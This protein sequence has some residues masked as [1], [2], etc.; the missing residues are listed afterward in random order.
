[1]RDAALYVLSVPLGSSRAEVLLQQSFHKYSLDHRDRRLQTELVYG[2]IRNLISLDHSLSFYMKE[3][4][5]VQPELKNILRLAAYQLL[6]L[7]K[8]PA[9]A[10]VDEAVKQAKKS[11]GRGG[12]GAGGFVNAVLRNML[13]EPG[14]VKFPDPDNKPIDYLALKFSYPAWLVK[15][16][17]E[18]FGFDGAMALMEAGNG[19]PPLVLRAQE[20]PGGQGHARRAFR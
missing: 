3:P 13:R 8:I 4:R 11:A 14:R 1:M 10:A 20:A 12:K 15:R 17:T 19:R 6:Y 18:R 9:R 2:V 5:K 7:D 16:W